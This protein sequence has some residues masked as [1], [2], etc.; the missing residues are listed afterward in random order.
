MEISDFHVEKINSTRGREFIVDRHYTGTCHGGP[1]CWGIL[2]DGDNLYGVC[3][4]ATPIS[5]N[6]RKSIWKDGVASEMKNHTTELHRLV[7]LDETPHNTETWFISKALDGLKEYKNKYKAVISFADMTEGHSGIIYQAS[8][9][10]YYGMTD[11]NIFYR[12][13]DGNL[14]APRQN[15]VNISKEDAIERG[16]EPEKRKSKHRYLFLLPDQYESKDDVRKL[17]DISEQEYPDN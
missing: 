3:A 7:T 5:E 4:F 6:V 2:D 9:A 17:L 16:W 8:N 15:G 11:E 14:R 10:I 13:Q 12:D 1:M